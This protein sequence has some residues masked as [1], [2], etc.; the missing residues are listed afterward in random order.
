MA[1]TNTLPVCRTHTRSAR[2]NQATNLKIKGPEEAQRFA[3]VAV[4]G[5]LSF[6]KIGRVGAGGRIGGG[7][8]LAA[9]FIVFEGGE[10]SGK[11][12]QAELLH[13][14][15]VESQHPAVLV[16]EPGTTTL[17]LHLREYLKSK[18]RLT[19]ESELLLFVAARAQLVADQIRP[20]LEQGVHVIA[21]RFTGSTVAYQGHGRGIKRDVIDYLNDYVTGGL[22]PDVTFL[23]DIDP[24][25][26]LHR[27]GKPQLQMALLSSDDDGVGRAD[28]AGHRRF[29]DQS[30][31]FHNRVRRGYRELSE[32]SPGWLTMNARLP[33]EE[34]A[35]QIWDEVAPLVP[36]A[37]SDE[38][39]VSTLA[40]IPGK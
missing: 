8:T 29:E 32:T 16:R 38:G 37:L 2:E 9:L 17:G 25:E 18:Q 35:A 10:G 36:L 14:R 21:D 23:L 31:A 12:T 40:L 30:S 20:S 13:R 26:G 27:V 24:E 15:L 28:V 6:G 7:G 33:V 22:Y 34:L 1:R 19:T 11:S 5:V 3:V 4:A 39:A